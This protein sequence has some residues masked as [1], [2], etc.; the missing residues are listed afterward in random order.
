MTLSTP[1]IS[2]GKLH[3]KE[4]IANA[5]RSPVLLAREY[6]DGEKRSTPTVSNS[7]SKNNQNYVSVPQIK[8]LDNIA[9]KP[10]LPKMF[11]F[12][13]IEQK[14]NEL[15]SGNE[16]EIISRIF[17]HLRKNLMEGEK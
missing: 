13:E 12:D 14:A 16:K 1:L 11:T 4:A 17:M 10:G 2:I 5:I 6:Y 15:A 7:S 3:L 8:Q 9:S